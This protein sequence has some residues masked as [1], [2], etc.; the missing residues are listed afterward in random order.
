MVRKWSYL[1]TLP[2]FTIGLLRSPLHLFR[3]W[4]AFKV[5]KKKTRHR[6]AYQGYLVRPRRRHYRNRKLK[7]NFYALSYIFYTWVKNYLKY[8]QFL[9]F[10]QSIGVTS[11][12]SQSTHPLFTT[13]LWEK[14]PST[15]GFSTYS[16]SNKIIKQ[17]SFLQRID[18]Y[19]YRTPLRDAPSTGF[20]MVSI[21]DMQANPRMNPGV[22]YLDK[23]LYPFVTSKE[24]LSPESHASLYKKQVELSTHYQLNWIYSLY[25]ISI[26][27]ILQFI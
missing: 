22:I 12:H 25:R 11:A 18:S 13:M 26:L 20:L 23:L 15:S 2:S 5:F 4:H 1:E 21:E 16:C 7:R 3:K 17:F 19:Q 8:K 6:K 24:L 27:L 9:R 10:Y 14:T